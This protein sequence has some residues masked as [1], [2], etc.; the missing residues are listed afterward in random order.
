M[1]A[2]RKPANF[3]TLPYFAISKNHF[4]CCKDKGIS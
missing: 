4:V 1:V 2:I 3:Y